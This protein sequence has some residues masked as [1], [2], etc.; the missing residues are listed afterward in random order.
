MTDVKT[1][2]IFHIPTKEDFHREYAGEITIEDFC[3]EKTRRCKIPHY[4]QSE[5]VAKR[6]KKS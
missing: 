3:T 2:C 5:Y 6:Q 4:T 1:N